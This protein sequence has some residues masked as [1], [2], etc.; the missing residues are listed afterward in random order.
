MPRIPA[1]LHLPAQSARNSGG[2]ARAPAVV[3]MEAYAHQLRTPIGAGTAQGVVANDGTA[4]LS[5]GPQGV[6]TRWYPS[7]VLVSTSSGPPDQSQCQLYRDFIDPKQEVGQTQQGG[8]DTLSFTHEMQPGNLLYAVWAR[9][10]PGDLVTITVHGDQL[11]L[12][13]APV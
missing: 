11:A 6:G 7:A 5:I 12:A 2:R 10:N 1:G 8:G 4:M 9:A 13:T 3:P